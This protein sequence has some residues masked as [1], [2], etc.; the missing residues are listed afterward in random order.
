MNINDIKL[1]CYAEKDDDS[2]FTICIDLNL[3]ARGETFED[4]KQA[5]HEIIHRYVTEAVTVDAKYIDDLIPRKA[6]FRFIFRYHTLSLL[7][8]VKRFKEACSFS[9]HLPL[10]P[11]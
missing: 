4:V 5:L 7:S 11:A 1:R 3:Y 9:E 6:P 2:W 8:H 10:V